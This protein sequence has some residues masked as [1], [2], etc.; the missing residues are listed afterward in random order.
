MV[1]AYMR[2]I[3]NRL[4]KTNEPMRIIALLNFHTHRLVGCQTSLRSQLFYHLSQNCLISTGDSLF[5]LISATRSPCELIV[6]PWSGIRLRPSICP[7]VKH[8]KE[9]H[10]KKRLEYQS[11]ILFVGEQK[12]IPGNWVTWPKWLPRL[13]IMG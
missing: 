3:T 11:Q 12:F 10:L 13:Y 2:T 4:S 6:Y 1:N 7:T 8:Y 9:L 5:L